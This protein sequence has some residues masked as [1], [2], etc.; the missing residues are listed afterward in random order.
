MSKNN[1]T[2][3]TN[4]G[5]SGYSEDLFQGLMENR[6]SKIISIIL[7]SLLALLVFS[8]ACGII[9]FEKFGSDQRRFFINKMVSSVCWSVIA[10]LILVQIPDILF[11]IYLPF[12]ELYCLFYVVCR[13]ATAVQMVCFLDAII[14][15]R[16]ISI[17][18]LKNPLNFKDDFWCL[19]INTWVVLFRWDC[20]LKTLILD[21][22]WHSF[23]SKK[24]QKILFYHFVLLLVISHMVINYW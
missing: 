7:A 12:P 5:S 3:F 22:I 21:I 20:L 4:D 1:C 9:W 2:T 11:H 17:F 24:E 15:F 6:L 13:N 10:S 16:Y 18:W 23:F 8:L 14:I 19:F